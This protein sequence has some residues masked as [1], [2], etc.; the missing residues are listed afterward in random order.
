MS[1]LPATLA[2]AA[3]ARSLASEMPEGGALEGAA[4]APG[5][6]AVGALVDLVLTLERN[7]ATF[8]ALPDSEPVPES[9]SEHTRESAPKGEP[10]DPSRAA[11]PP[12]L[13]RLIAQASGD[14]LVL[15]TLIDSAF[16]SSRLE[17]NV[18]SVESARQSSEQAALERER[19]IDEAIDRA[20][21]GRRL[22]KWLKKLLK[23]IAIVASVVASAFTGGV[24]AAV[25]IAG[26]VLMLAAPHIGKLAIAL[27]MEP[28]DAKWLVLGLQIVGAALSMA[29]GGAAGAA[30]SAQAASALERAAELTAR[31]VGAASQVLEGS[32]RIAHSAFD[33]QA[34]KAESAAELADV[35]F[36]TASLGLEDAARVLRDG[37]RSLER[38]SEIRSDLLRIRAE[39]TQA[40]LQ[41]AI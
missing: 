37:M 18:Q 32:E 8:G 4:R 24:L 38:A 2:S 22:P 31:V 19:A 5:A 26:I 40:I 21:R 28:E 36:D 20:G 17:S 29:S 33:Y 15:L 1:A 13:E 25:A 27:G 3:A 10:A 7:R 34:A 41:R 35:R 30:S 39:A 14:P 16:Q 9:P 6:A 23:A 11:I 12:E